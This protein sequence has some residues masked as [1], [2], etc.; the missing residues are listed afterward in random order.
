M[1]DR[2]NSH[3]LETCH[4]FFHYCLSLSYYEVNTMGMSERGVKAKGF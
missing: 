4:L 3:Q 1:L 2:V